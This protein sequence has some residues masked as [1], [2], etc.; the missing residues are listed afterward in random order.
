MDYDLLLYK[1]EQIKDELITGGF[2][3]YSC[4]IDQICGLQRWKFRHKDGRRRTL[5]LCSHYRAYLLLTE[6]D[7][8]LIHLKADD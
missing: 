1:F 6:F 4:D 3:M 2:K 8:I 7:K 5:Y